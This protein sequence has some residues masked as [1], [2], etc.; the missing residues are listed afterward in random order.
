MATDSYWVCSGCKSR[1]KAKGLFG[2]LK[3]V[4]EQSLA[5]CQCGQSLSLE[6]I[7]AFALGASHNIFMVS[8]AYLPRKIET[9]DDTEG[10][11]VS[12]YPFMVV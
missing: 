2:A 7:F 3:S 4:A 11:K 12:F 5:P 9:W 6:L 8:A 10:N 1:T